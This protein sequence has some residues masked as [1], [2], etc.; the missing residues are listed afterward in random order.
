MAGFNENGDVVSYMGRHLEDLMIDP[1]SVAGSHGF[2]LHPQLMLWYDLDMELPVHY[3][4]RNPEV[5]VMHYLCEGAKL[6]RLQETMREQL[7][8]KDRHDRQPIHHAAV[9]NENR[10]VLQYIL[11][12]GGPRRFSRIG[13][14]RMSPSV[15]CVKEK[16]LAEYCGGETAGVA[17]VGLEVAVHPSSASQVKLQWLSDKTRSGWLSVEDLAEPPEEQIGGGAE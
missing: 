17:R 4:A 6:A 7:S 15:W 10:E 12:V 13:W 9:F 11:T 2:G 3:A 14:D 1:E 16:A 8:A 5:D